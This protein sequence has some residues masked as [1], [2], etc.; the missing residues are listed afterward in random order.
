V[1]APEP[2]PVS[3]QLQILA[4]EHANLA[5]TRAMIWNEIFSRSAMYL[6]T[7]SGAIVALALVG[8]Q[9]AFGETF[10]NFAILILPLVLFIGFATWLRMHTSNAID[11]YC[12]IGMNR[13]RATY[14]K[15]A[16]E[17]QSAF[18]MGITDD[19]VGVGRTMGSHAGSPSVL[20]II[21]A[22]PVII[23]TVNSAVLGVLTGL[24]AGRIGL[25]FAGVV[26]LA[27]LAFAIAVITQLRHA[28]RHIARTQAANA[29]RFPR[30]DA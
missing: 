14:V 25:P 4:S 26:A 6:A 2:T 22:T 10:S 18:V 17:L 16:P 27:A 23:L 12:V 28:R 3:V 15:L 20:T 29:P 21:S 1:A 5:T 13:I 11:A 19:V 24:V 30:P 9:S 8:Q 7:L